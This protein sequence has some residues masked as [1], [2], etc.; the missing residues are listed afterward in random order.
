MSEN[1]KNLWIMVGVIA[2]LLVFGGIFGKKL[3][4]VISSNS[5]QLNLGPSQKEEIKISPAVISLQDSFANVA[6]K[7]KPAVVNITAT[8]MIRQ[9]YT[10]FEFYFGDPFEDFFNEFFGQPRQ[11]RPQRSKPQ[12]KYFERKFS[13]TGSGVIISEDGYIL[14]N[15]HVVSDATEINV[16][17]SD[18]RKFKG[19]IIGQDPKTDLA[20]IKISTSGKLPAASLGDSDSIRVGD[21]SV[22][23]GSPFGLEQ[24]VTVGIISAKR[25]SLIVEGQQYRDLVQTDAAI[26]QGNSGGPLLN[27]KGEVI[28]INTAIYTPTGGFVGVGFAIPINRAKAV[29][30]QLI[31]KGK[32]TRGWLGVEIR[33]VDEAVAK[34]FGLKEASGA[35]VNN[36]M[37]DTPAEKAGL[38]RG[39]IILEY[40][41]KTVKDVTHLQ[42]LV[43]QTEPKKKVKI[44][45]WRNNKEEIF[46]LVTG[47]M[48][49]KIS[50]RKEGVPEERGEVGAG[51]E[52]VSKE[53]L[54]LKVKTL[55]KEMA[56]QLQVDGQEKGVVIVEL[57]P[58]SKAEEAGLM[59]ND[60]IRSINRRPVSNI[61]EFE[62]VTAKAKL[63]D[64][65][66][67]DINRQGK[68]IYL[69]IQEK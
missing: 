17:L 7:V 5:E 68:L 11:E 20:V 34:Q 60:I 15:N 26:N 30:G 31:E 23:I 52:K 33:P 64:G 58:G 16:T 12:K 14:T 29:L 50:E 10:P 57:T 54:G 9:E 65:V 1:R 61:K 49:G 66:V 46:E 32:V 2:A 38:R 48:P 13:G 69:T 37:K 43:S 36:V 40:D 45:V 18:E 21:W 8:H 44:K 25:Q 55:T 56:A 62:Q 24:T 39:D 28:G 22:A 42:D 41:G 19:K 47:E 3:G 35:L 51:E 53:W 27:I 4:L 63:A 67:F 6:E 59:E